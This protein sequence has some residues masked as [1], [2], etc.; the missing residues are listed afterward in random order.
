MKVCQGGTLFPKR[1][2]RQRPKGSALC[3]DHQ[4]TLPQ[5]VS[6]NLRTPK[7]TSKSS[8]GVGWFFHESVPQSVAFLGP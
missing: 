1:I 4:R 7:L 6:G 2:K 3:S 8:F 5:P